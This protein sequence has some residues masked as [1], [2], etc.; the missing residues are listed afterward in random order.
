MNPT[1]S[2]LLT[3]LVLVTSTAALAAG[4]RRVIAA[5][6]P[7]TTLTTAAMAFA[8]EEERVAQDLYQLAAEKWG[9]AVFT[10]IRRSETQHVAALTQLA[11]RYRL[12]VPA[13]ER[14]VYQTADLQALYTSL[15]AL[16]AVSPESAL[17]VG[18]LV[19]ETDIVDLR[20][21]MATITDAT[22]LG[23]MRRLEAASWNHLAAFVRNLA[24]LGI[25][26]QPQVLDPEEYAARID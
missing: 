26:Y 24:F 8:I 3:A 1:R 13:A 12:P 5:P 19:E 22:T 14:G 6:A 7:T 20:E 16:V 11:V 9:L 18:A 21:S 23:V 10:N 17:S 4:P 15:A 2:L 25:V